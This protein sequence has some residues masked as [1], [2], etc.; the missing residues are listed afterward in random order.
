MFHSIIS[1]SFRVSLIFL[2]FMIIVSPYA[3]FLSCFPFQ[4]FRKTN[5]NNRKFKFSNLQQ[6]EFKNKIVKNEGNKN[7][8]ELRNEYEIKNKNECENENENENERT[9]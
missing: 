1:H 6:L 8:S 5:H 7:E 4:F 3:F 9:K 2:F